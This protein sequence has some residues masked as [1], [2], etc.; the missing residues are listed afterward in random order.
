LLDLLHI[1]GDLLQALQAH[2]RVASLADGVSS[3]IDGF[4]VMLLGHLA[5]PSF[6]SLPKARTLVG[7]RALVMNPRG[8]HRARGVA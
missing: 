4:A 7:K 5:L 6:P 8:R 3:P 2:V 1:A